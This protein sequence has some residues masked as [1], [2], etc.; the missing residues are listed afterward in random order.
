MMEILLWISQRATDEFVPFERQMICSK[1]TDT[2]HL[3]EIKTRKI[4]VLTVGSKSSQ[5]THLP[6]VLRDICF[7][8]Y[9]GQNVY[10]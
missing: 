5:K 7:D 1:V 4:T 3:V 6:G 8:S 2:T 10:V 9:P